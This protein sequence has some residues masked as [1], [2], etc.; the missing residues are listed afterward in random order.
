MSTET[1]GFAILT[2]GVGMTVVFSALILL[3][4]IMVALPILFAGPPEKESGTAAGGLPDNGKK[5]EPGPDE[6]DED[7]TPLW[8]IAGAIAY[9]LEEERTRTPRAS[10]WTA[11]RGAVMNR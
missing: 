2:A 9:L 8:A 4:L 3:S 1:I 7:G 6:V 10:S 5:E 11:R